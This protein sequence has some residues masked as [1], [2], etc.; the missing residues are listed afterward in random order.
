MPSSFKVPTF[1]AAIL[2][3]GMVTALGAAHAQQTN[4]G[5]ITHQAQTQAEQDA[6]DELTGLARAEREAAILTRHGLPAGVFQGELRGNINSR[7][8][9]PG[10]AVSLTLRKPATLPDGVVIA[11]GSVVLGH[12][13]QAAAHTKTYKNGAVLLTFDQVVPKGAPEFS[14]FALISVI[15][16]SMSEQT[17]LTGAFHE[18]TIGGTSNSPSAGIVSRGGLGDAVIGQSS[19]TSGIDGVMVVASPGGSGILL[20]INDNIAMEKTQLITLVGGRATPEAT[21]L[22]AYAALHPATKPT[23]ATK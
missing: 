8:A 12:V 18:G 9:K 10:D 4:P 23:Q 17:E 15:A 19:K 11:Q 7:N 13:V 5:V 14:L 20:A 1:P 2:L 21:T 6:I 16:P 22:R 3:A